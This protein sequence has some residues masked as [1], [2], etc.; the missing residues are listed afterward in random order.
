MEKCL[1]VSVTERE[2]QLI[3]CLREAEDGEA[4]ITVEDNEPCQVDLIR[5]DIPLE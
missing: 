5:R 3:R 4:V 1:M 2:M